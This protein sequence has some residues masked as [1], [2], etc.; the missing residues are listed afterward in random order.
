MDAADDLSDTTSLIS[1][2]S[3]LATPS[4]PAASFSVSRRTSVRAGGEM[5]MARVDMPMARAD[6]PMARVAGPARGQD[7]AP[8]VSRDVAGLELDVGWDEKIVYKVGGLRGFRRCL[9]RNFL[10]ASRPEHDAPGD[11][12]LMRKLNH[13]RLIYPRLHGVPPHGWSFPHPYTRT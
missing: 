7:I 2:R 13:R 10:F 8:N 3:R 9:A 4:I 1:P 12:R 6:M 5:S 11:V